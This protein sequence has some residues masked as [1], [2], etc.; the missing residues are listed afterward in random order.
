MKSRFSGWAVAFC[1]A[2]VLSGCSSMRS[3]FPGAGFQSTF[4]GSVASNSESLVRSADFEGVAGEN[5]AETSGISLSAANTQ[6]QF[7]GS[8]GP[9]KKTGHFSQLSGSFV[10]PSANQP[11]FID[12]TI[13]MDSLKTK[14]WLLTKHLK[15]KDFFD[16][17]QYPT[18]RF[19]STSIRPTQQPDQYL[20]AGRLTIHG[21]T[22]NIEVPATIKAYPDGTQFQIDFAI[23]QTDFGMDR[24]AKKT[25]NEVPISVF[26]KLTA[27]R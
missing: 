21:V 17:T 3:G 7:T 26:A 1:V 5:T 27:R 25:K 4:V 22:R 10:A 12:I 16:A 8:A 13:N 19:V 14:N 20:V 6:V 24:G 18:S 15:S 2:I 9:M 23:L 11:G